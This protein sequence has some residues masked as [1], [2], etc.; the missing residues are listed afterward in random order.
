MKYLRW[1]LLPIS[2]LYGLVVTIRNWCYDAGWFKSTGFEIPVISVGNLA[3]GGAGK[4]PMTEYLVRLLSN[5]KKIATLSRGYGR[6]TKGFLLAGPSS[7]AAQVGDE[8]AQFKQKFPDLTVAV[9]EDRVAGINRLKDHHELII[10]DDAYQHRAVKPGLSILLFDYAKLNEPAF[11]LPAGDLREPMSGRLRADILVVSKCPLALGKAEMEKIYYRLKPYPYQSLFFTGISYSRFADLKGR[12]V[13]AT[14]TSTTQIFLLTGIATTEPIKQYLAKYS[15]HIVH[16]KYPDHHQFSLKNIAKLAEAFEAEA[17]T[18]KV[19]ITT[20]KDA[21]RLKDDIF[22]PLLA[23][24]PLWVLPI[25]VQFL[26]G[27]EQFD[28]LITDYVR[29]HSTDSSIY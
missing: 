1:L 13:E 3:V 10:L 20:E 29:Q 25:E 26:N 28:Q 12:P 27:R 17:G 19:V 22:Q 8:P 5:E 24:L 23:R 9:C 11:L 4:S 7:T 18:D 14:I 15:S 6:E 2:W 21:Q 16:H